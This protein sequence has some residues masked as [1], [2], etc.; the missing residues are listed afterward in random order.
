MKVGLYDHSFFGRNKY[1]NFG[2]VPQQEAY[3]ERPPVVEAKSPQI[4]L[5]EFDQKRAADFAIAAIKAM[6]SNQ[7]AQDANQVNKGLDYL[8]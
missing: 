5:S 2:K 1:I 6:D 4:Q 7:I 3:S 8:I